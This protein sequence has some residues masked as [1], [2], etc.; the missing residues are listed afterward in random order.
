MNNLVDWVKD[1][2]PNK[3]FW[4][5]AKEGESIEGVVVDKKQGN[6]GLQLTL[7]LAD[8]SEVKTPSHKVL[9][10]RLQNKEVGQILKLVYTGQL[11]PRVRGENP[12]QTY[13]VYTKKVDAPVE[14]IH[15]NE[16]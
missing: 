14:A 16:G 12:I 3:E 7:Q 10:N 13:D 11:A 4:K 2:T 6:F 15:K 5:P 8:G 1:E 9:Q